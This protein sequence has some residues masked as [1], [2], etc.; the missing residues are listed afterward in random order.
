MT[1]NSQIIHQ[2][3]PIRNKSKG[4]IAPLYTSTV[5]AMS[6]PSSD[7]G[8]QY[9]RIGNP[10]RQLLEKN[11][12]SYADSKFCLAFSS[13]S[14][15]IGALLLTFSSG[16]T[17]IC[18][19][20][21][22]EGTRRL[23]TQIF[24][25]MG[26]TTEYVDCSNI[27]LLQ[28]TIEKNRSVR[29]VI[30]ETPTNPLLNLL[31]IQMV[32]DLAHQHNILVAV[33]NSM[34]TSLLQKPLNFGADAV[35][36]SLS[37][38]INGHSDVIGGMLATNNRKL[39]Q[40]LREI[41]RTF[42]I[43]LSPQD[44]YQVLRGMK[45]LTLRLDKQISNAQI[46]AQLLKKHPKVAKVYL[47]NPKGKMINQMITSGSIISFNLKTDPENFLKKLKL[48]IIGHSFGGVET[49][50]QQPRIMMDLSMSEVPLDKL[51]IDKSFFRLSIGIEPVQDIIEDL[52]NA[53]AD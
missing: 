13:G 3:N 53:L 24:Q 1:T 17:V 26:I 38:F 49:V 51:G 30:F 47:P 27:A 46:V 36:E 11:L 9:G 6:E 43:S 8:F 4:I 23:L 32:C 12:A 35:I 5:F 25:K 29:L 7:A 33:D 34:A 50:I 37:K 14:S 52:K 48:I 39:F 28:T 31:D 41:Y 40:N 15:A 18:H 19:S 2:F 10:T 22:Y 44:A 42:G 21:I 16:D 20:E 45:T